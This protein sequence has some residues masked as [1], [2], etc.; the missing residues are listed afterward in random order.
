M[1]IYSLENTRVY[2]RIKVYKKNCKCR[3][4]YGVDEFAVS[5]MNLRENY[6]LTE[7]ARDYKWVN[8]GHYTYAY[9]DGYPYPGF[10]YEPVY[11]QHEKCNRD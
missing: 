1:D 4:P 6:A 10:I 5:D 9:I 8:I 3:L 2:I 7:R 11:S